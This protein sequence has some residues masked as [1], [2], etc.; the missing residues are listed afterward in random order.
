MDQHRAKVEERE[1]LDLGQDMREKFGDERGWKM[2]L[3]YDEKLDSFVEYRERVGAIHQGISYVIREDRKRPVE[4][5][6]RN[7]HFNEEEEG[8][9]E[10]E[11]GQ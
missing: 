5:I 2:S 7:Q 9:G 1:L 10:I 4:I 6:R 3:K 8:E 11:Q